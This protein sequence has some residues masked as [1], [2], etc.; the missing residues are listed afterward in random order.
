MGD[1]L[2]MVNNTVLVALGA[3]TESLKSATICKKDHFQR[4][5]TRGN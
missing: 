1:T 5:G 4:R 3:A 2:V